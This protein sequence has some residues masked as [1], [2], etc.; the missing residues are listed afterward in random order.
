MRR[1]FIWERAAHIPAGNEANHL[2][3]RKSLARK[4]RNVRVEILLWLRHSRQIGLSG[5]HAS[6]TKIYFRAPAAAA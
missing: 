6:A 3:L 4:C 5:V 2:S 1:A